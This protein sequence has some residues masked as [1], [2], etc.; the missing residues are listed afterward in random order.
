MR[1][2]TIF[3]FVG[4]AGAALA[5]SKFPANLPAEWT[6]CEKDADCAATP[7]ICGPAAAVRREHLEAATRLDDRG[8]L[9]VKQDPPAAECLK[10]RCAVKH[11]GALGTLGH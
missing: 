7:P 4:A 6:T 10:G 3:I 9:G 1:A 8:C 2:L 11:T 5:D